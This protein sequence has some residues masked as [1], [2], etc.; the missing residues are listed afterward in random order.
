MRCGT[1]AQNSLLPHGEAGGKSGRLDDGHSEIVEWQQLVFI[2]PTIA[3][4]R[5]VER[6]SGCRSVDAAYGG[7]P[8][9]ASE[10][11]A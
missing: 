9:R 8:P 5:D 2:G 4:L 10:L 6:D 11:F 3:R 1:S 7:C